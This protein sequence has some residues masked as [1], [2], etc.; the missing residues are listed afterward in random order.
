[1]T[2]VYLAINAIMYLGFGIWCGLS[3]YWTSEAVGF[4]LIGQKGMSEY[5][6][7]YGGL[8]FGIGLFY[9]LSVLDSKLTYPALVFSVCFY[10]SLAIFRTYSIF[11]HGS[12]L[13]SAYYFFSAEVL[14]SIFAI[15]LYYRAS[16]S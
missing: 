8:Q 16:P 9:L 14:L 11:K 3:P 15:I 1:M 4:N 12:D 2:S 10:P 5:T 7:V 13:Q 6:A